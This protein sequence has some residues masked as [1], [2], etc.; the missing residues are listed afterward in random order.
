LSLKNIPTNNPEKCAQEFK[1]F[2]C[3]GYYQN[4]QKGFLAPGASIAF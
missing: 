1:G 3:A 2:S 4:F